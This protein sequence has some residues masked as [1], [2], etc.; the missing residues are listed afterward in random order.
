[1]AVD[2]PRLRLQSLDYFEVGALDD[3]AFKIDNPQPA[4]SSVRLYL[5]AWE[6]RKTYPRLTPALVRRAID[7]NRSPGS[8]TTS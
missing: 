4:S 7:W 1:V 8:T 5:P 6:E 3:P 2:L